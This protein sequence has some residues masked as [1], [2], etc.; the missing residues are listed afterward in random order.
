MA[1]YVTTVRTAKTPKQVFAYM[2]DLRNFAEWDPGVKA[3]KQ[4]KGSGG[5]ADAVFD[6]TV[7]GIGRDLTLRYVTEEYDAPRNLLVVARS[8]VF[9]SIDRIT[10][11]P[12]G[13]G[14]VLTYDADLRLNGVLRLGDLGLR[15]VFGRIGDRAA[16]GLRRVLDAQAV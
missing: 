15:L 9:T 7:A 11:K 10:V 12:D 2:A 4:V 3:V 13:K 8:L 5:G 14:S 1:R 6:V 16:A